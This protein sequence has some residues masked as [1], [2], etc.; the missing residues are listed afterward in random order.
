[1]DLDACIK[2]RR[3]VRA[4]TDEPVSKGQIESVLEA[5]VWAPTGMDREPWKFVV[6]EDKKLIKYV[7]EE[8]KLLVQ[9]MMPSMATHFQTEEDVICYDAPVLMLICTEKDKEEQFNDLNLLDSVLAAQNIFLK[10][11]ELGLGTCYMGFVMLLRTKP[12]V[13]KKVGVPDGYDLMV[14]LIMGHPKTEQEPGKRNK[15][16]VL[17]WIR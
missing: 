9:Q 7:S 6:I 12:D 5:G 11:H 2:G 15:P 14:P 1:M 10:A 3:S 4:Y 8:T 17:K 13:L 16:N